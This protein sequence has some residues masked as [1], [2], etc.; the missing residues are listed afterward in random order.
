M[1]AG[2]KIGHKFIAVTD[3]SRDADLEGALRYWGPKGRQDVAA[4]GDGRILNVYAEID[5]VKKSPLKVFKGIE[6]NLLPDG[7]FDS[8]L[9]ASSEVQC[10]NC[11]IHPDSDRNGF[12]YIINNPKLYAALVLKGI[13]NKHTNIMCH[14]GYGC[15]PNVIE[16]LDW[17]AI[18][19]SA[20]ESKVAIEINLKSLMDLIFRKILNFEEFPANSVKYQKYFK[21]EIE[22]EKSKYI[23][24]LGNPQIRKEMKSYFKNGLKIAIN[25]DQH[26]NP[27]IGGEN[28]KNEN[29]FHKFNDPLRDNTT[30]RIMRIRFV[31]CLKIAE[32]EF[33]KLFDEQGITIENIL[34]SYSIGKLS[35]FFKKAI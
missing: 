35:A 2:G 16:S 25:T 26:W 10:V 33:Q 28:A 19:R 31:R 12:K 30:F 14:I 22:N 9:P 27:F 34:N 8:E 11:S 4:Y 32:E 29:E 17:N 21:K 6:V 18:C 20:I 15:E 24:L 3:H 5:A 23:P 7:R 1:Y 13:Q